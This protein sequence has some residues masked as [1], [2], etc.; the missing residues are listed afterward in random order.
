[1]RV[2]AF[3]LAWLLAAALPALAYETDQYSHRLDTLTDSLPLM[4]RIVNAALQRVAADWQGPQD[5]LLL[6]RR[7]YFALGGH[8]W[9]DRVEHTATQSERIDRTPA[10]FPQSVYA[11][12]GPLEGR[13]TW[14][15]G[16]GP[17]IQLGGTLIGVDKFGHFFSQGFKY[18]RRY[19]FD[20][21]QVSPAL[22]RQGALV[23]GG[24]FGMV[25]TGV[26]SNADIVANYEGLRFYRNLLEDVDGRG[27]LFAW[28]DGRP[29]L[30]RAFSWQNYVN[31]FWDEA[32]NGSSLTPGMERIVRERLAAL[33]ERYRGAPMSRLR[34]RNREG[35]VRRYAEIGMRPASIPEIG[36]VCEGGSGGGR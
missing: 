11:A 14:L 16:V 31:D 18:Y 36:A 27:A 29:A 19:I 9:V 22:L 13:V 32:L 33:C 21:R 7:V 5:D 6:A 26:Y 10:D 4:D 28:R 24:Y 23:E 2:G 20:G 17:S 34:A 30:Q 35:L 12:A 3:L 25:T 1:M 8:Y 15:F